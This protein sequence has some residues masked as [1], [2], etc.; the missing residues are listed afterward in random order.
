MMLP[1]RGNVR[2]DVVSTARPRLSIHPLS[3]VRFEALKSALGVGREMEQV[4][5]EIQELLR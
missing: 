5:T 4:F 1:R 3:D 2:L